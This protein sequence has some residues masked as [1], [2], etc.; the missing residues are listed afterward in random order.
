MPHREQRPRE[1]TNWS[2]L[3]C[4]ERKKKRLQEQAETGMHVFKGRGSKLWARTE[5]AEHSC[6]PTLTVDVGRGLRLHF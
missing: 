3:I 5:V 1:G 4:G 2:Q 6:W